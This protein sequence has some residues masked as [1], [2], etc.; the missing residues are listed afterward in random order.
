VE[1]GWSRSGGQGVPRHVRNL[2]ALHNSRRCSRRPLCFA[3]GPDTGTGCYE[4]FLGFVQRARVAECVFQVYPDRLLPH[5]AQIT[6]LTQH[7][8]F[9]SSPSSIWNTKLRCGVWY[10]CFLFDVFRV[11]LCTRRPVILGG[12]T[13]FIGLSC[14]VPRYLFVMYLKTFLLC[15]HPY[16]P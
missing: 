6:A 13:V 4:Y 16:H 3:L 12:L 7:Q 10:L 14:K 8:S 2:S 1:D 15:V 9:S 11:P 5:P